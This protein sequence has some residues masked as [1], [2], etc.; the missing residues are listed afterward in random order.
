MGCVFVIKFVTVITISHS[1]VGISPM[2][3]LP[4][5]ILDNLPKM[6]LSLC[7]RLIRQHKRVFLYCGILTGIFLKQFYDF[8]TVQK[9]LNKYL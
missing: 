9:E 2:L 1:E 4:A 3:I 7:H 8:K 5:I 6:H